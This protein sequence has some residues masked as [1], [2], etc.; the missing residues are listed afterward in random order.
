MTAVLITPSATRSDIYVPGNTDLAESG[1]FSTTT[2]QPIANNLEWHRSRIPGCATLHRRDV[3]L[4]T[5]FRAATSVWGSGV[6]SADVE[7]W[8]QNLDAAYGLT[9]DVTGVVPHTCTI[10]GYGAAIAPNGPHSDL[11]ALKPT[12]E[13]MRRPLTALPSVAWTTLS[14]ATDP[15]ATV[16]IYDAA[17]LVGSSGASF[18]ANKAVAYR[19]AVRIVGETGTNFRAGLTVLAVWIE[20]GL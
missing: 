10:T 20:V 3:A 11:P 8:V 4:N 17:H 2:V 15:A 14:L 7:Y 19:W 9:F 13:L 16:A 12:V 1:S 18:A 6:S 5:G